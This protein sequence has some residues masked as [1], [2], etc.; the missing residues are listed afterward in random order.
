MIDDLGRRIDALE[1][2]SMEQEVLIDDLNATIT[3]QWRVIDA[4]KREIERLGER[5]DS[6]AAGP[7]SSENELPPHY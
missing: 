7:N 2:R 6:A 1:I 5:V 3:S 4:L